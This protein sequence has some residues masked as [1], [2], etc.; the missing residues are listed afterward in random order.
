MAIY[1][2]AR[3][4]IKPEARPK[5]EQAIREFIDYIKEHEPE[6]RL[7][8]SLQQAEDPTVFLHFFIFQNDEARDRH[9]G[10]D[11]VRRFTALL[12]PELQEPVEFTEFTLLA[13]T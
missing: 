10:S 1:Q 2:T 12:Y 4:R 8:M 9:A 7:Y 13:A 3:F 6:T 5:C 11:G